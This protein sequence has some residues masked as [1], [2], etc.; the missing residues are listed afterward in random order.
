MVFQRFPFGPLTY[1]LLARS[2]NND[3]VAYPGPFSCSNPRYFYLF[4]FF[5]RFF[6]FPQ[7]HVGFPRLVAGAVPGRQGAAEA[8]RGSHLAGAAGRGPRL[9]AGLAHGLPAAAAVAGAAAQPP[10]GR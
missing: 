9:A 1:E 10:G 2:H 4:I 5:G 8:R 7:G 3:Q 6:F